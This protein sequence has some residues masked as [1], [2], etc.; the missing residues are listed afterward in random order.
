MVDCRLAPLPRPPRAP[1]GPRRGGALHIA[2]SS[3][4]RFAALAESTEAV[5]KEVS[6]AAASSCCP[7]VFGPLSRLL[8]SSSSIAM[9]A[10]EVLLKLDEADGLGVPERDVGAMPLSGNLL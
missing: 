5:W 8:P 7:A 4:R 6:L 1:P 9:V 10:D 2:L 3:A